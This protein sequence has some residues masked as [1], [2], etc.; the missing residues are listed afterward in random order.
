MFH[1]DLFVCFEQVSIVLKRCIQH[2]HGQFNSVKLGPFVAVIASYSNCL[3]EPGRLRAVSER[4]ILLFRTDGLVHDI[5]EQVFVL[6]DI[7]QAGPG[8]SDE[9]PVYDVFCQHEP[10]ALEMYGR[11]QEFESRRELP[12]LDQELFVLQDFLHSFCRL[13]CIF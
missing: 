1:A 10:I 2:A 12:E 11:V 4:N 13:L 6:S 8:C 7:K 5:V 3:F 9:Q